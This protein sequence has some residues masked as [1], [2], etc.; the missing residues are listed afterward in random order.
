MDSK[1]V[2]PTPSGVTAG[3]IVL[4]IIV[5]G[6]L[7][8]AAVLQISLLLPVLMLGGIFATYLKV[9]DGWIPAA[10]LVA[11]A[12]AA[13]AWLLDG[14]LTLILF[15]ASLL[16]SLVVVRGVDRKAPFF[17]Q[18]KLG[19][20]AFGLGLLGAVLIAYASFGGGMVA[21]FVDLLRSEY[22][23]MP[24]AAL[25]PLV[26]WTNSLAPA[27]TFGREAVTV[28]YFRSQLS[29]ILDLMQ[30]TYAQILPGAL[31][32]GALLSG[33]LAVLWGNWTQARR[34]MATNESFVGMSGWFMPAGVSAGALALWLVG[35]ILL[36]SD[37]RSGATV[38][39][40]ISQT[41]GAAF[42][43]QALCA[44]DRRMLRS[45]SALS[46]RRTL[47]TLLAIGAL[48]FKS[49]ASVLSYVGVASALFGSR[50]ALKLWLQRRQDDH[51]DHDDFNQ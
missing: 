19:V 38:Y 26:E 9:R 47:I 27:G 44:L 20:A 35:M 34:G 15:V 45:G 40:T 50:G 24:D 11:A 16:P 36:Y 12:L 48:L 10:V 29:G 5:G 37:A 18:M 2:F 31:L 6:A 3:G 25:Q 51:S 33:M 1:Q 46:R 14:T 43:V 30:Q 42:A 32:S 7:P 21:R 13:S 49:L 17:D 4:E 39:M 22:D 8:L 23:R 41:T 28:D